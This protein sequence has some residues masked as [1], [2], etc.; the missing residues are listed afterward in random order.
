MTAN[1]LPVKSFHKTLR[2]FGAGLFLLALSAGCNR[3]NLG[4]RGCDDPNG[5]PED[6]E[7]P[8]TCPESDEWVSLVVSPNSPMLLSQDG[9]QPTQQF[10]VFGVR[11]DGSRSTKPLKAKF[12]APSNSIGAIDSGNGLFMASGEVGGTLMMSATVYTKASPLRGNFQITVKIL[13]TYY[14]PGTP[15]NAGT[16]FGTTPV[17]D[18]AKGAQLLYPLDGVVM[19]QNVYPADIQWQNGV[20][21]DLYKVTIVK[22]NI[23]VIAYS[24]HKGAGYT[25]DYLPEAKGWTGVAQSNPD[26]DAQLS[27]DRWESASGIVYS[28]GPPISMHFANGS[29]MGSIYYWDI[30]AGRIRR[31]D[32]GTANSVNFMPTPPMSPVTNETCMGCHVVSRDGRYMIG[33]LGGG[34][35]VGGIFDLTVSQSPTATPTYPITSTLQKFWFATWKPD[36]TRIF[37][38]ETPGGAANSNVFYL[39]DSANGAVVTPTS[40]ALPTRGTFPSWSPDGNKIVYSSEV[41]SWGGDSLTTANL[42]ILPVTGQDA[43]GTA[44]RIHTATS[45]TGST[46]DTYPTWSP[47][48]KWVV[49]HNGT[50]GRSDNNANGA[51][52]MIAPDGTGLTK[53]ALATDAGTGTGT[54]R[55]YFPNFSPFN[56]GGNFW[57]SYIS[58][59]PY[60]NAQVG[61]ASSPHQQ[62]WVSA[63]KNNPAPGE[64]PSCVPYWLPGQVRTAKNISAYWAPKACRQDSDSCSVGGECCSGLCQ[65]GKCQA[66]TG[67]QCRKLDETCGGSGCCDG[68]SCDTATHV[69]VRIIG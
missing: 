1:P 10:Q 57:L 62:L 53:L 42:S 29:L 33:R 2:V 59:R 41:N 54:G 20:A 24:L 56:V 8:A 25:F 12:E 35:N 19:P 47:D 11:Q 45:I 61:T 65:G 58:N 16:K 26:D 28:D 39:F 49:F 3:Q 13:R 63:V 36:N 4:D 67:S 9:S 23:T 64:D 30:A 38:S 46:V 6:C 50:D 15:S 37:G 43:F 68:L 52:Y 40:G 66:P 60:G 69:C 21:G 32:D 44:Q 14:T 51:L 5:C 27:V 34:D 7:D 22:P 18:P 17:R 48:S 31:I 55:V